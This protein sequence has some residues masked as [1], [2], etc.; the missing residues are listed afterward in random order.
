[1]AANKNSLGF[2][3]VSNMLVSIESGGA[4]NNGNLK[5][6]KKTAEAPQ[7]D[8]PPLFFSQINQNN[9]ALEKTQKG[10]ISNL[11][12]FDG[13]HAFNTARVDQIVNH[14]AQ[15]LQLCNTVAPNNIEAE[16]KLCFEQIQSLTIVQQQMMQKHRDII[17]Q[18]E[19]LIELKNKEIAELMAISKNKQKA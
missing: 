5:P 12:A 16:R 4:A 3:D 17:S 8:I 2:E 7:W 19:K 10:V 9:S 13:H 14:H 6:A 18:T 15:N 11:S 1:M